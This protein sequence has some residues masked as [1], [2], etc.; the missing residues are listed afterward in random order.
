M[1]GTKDCYCGKQIVWFFEK[2]TIIACE[3]CEVTFHVSAL[4]RG[5]CPYCGDELTEFVKVNK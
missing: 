1:E 4:K 3:N 5:Y 2:P